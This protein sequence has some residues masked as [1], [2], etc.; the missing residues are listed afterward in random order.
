MKHS[1]RYCMTGE[2]AEITDR[3]LGDFLL[4]CLGKNDMAVVNAMISSAII[5]IAAHCQ[6]TGENFDE[7]IDQC[8]GLFDAAVKVVGETS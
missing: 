4:S 8:R 5:L 3:L 7:V 6:R 2:T 1:L